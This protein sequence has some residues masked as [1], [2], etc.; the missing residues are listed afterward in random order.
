MNEQISSGFK[1]ITLL[2]LN[3]E[4]VFHVAVRTKQP[5]VTRDAHLLAAVKLWAINDATTLWPALLKQALTLQGLH[6]SVKGT[7]Y[8]IGL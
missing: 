3:V 8:L 4:C 6:M 5:R 1:A 7:A 2:D